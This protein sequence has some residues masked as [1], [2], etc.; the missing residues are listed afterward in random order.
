MDDKDN[1]QATLSP[2]EQLSDMIWGFTKAQLIYVAAKLEIADLLT[3]GPKDAQALALSTKINAQVLYRLMRGLAWCGLVVHLADDRF[4]LTPLGQCLQT[5]APASF[6]ENAL[7][8][9]EIDWPAWGALLKGIEIGKPGFE[10]AFGM[11]IFEYFAQ[12]EEAGSRF[13]R[14][15]GKVSAAV[16]AGIISVYDFSSFKTFIDIGGGNGTLAAAIL[17]A[18]PH[19]RGIIFDL[20][21]VIERTPLHLMPIEIADRCKAIGGD[22]FTSVPAGGDVYLMKWIIHDWPDDRCV[23]ILENCHKVMAKD[24]RLLIVEMVMP[25]QAT[26]STP[27]VMWDLH[28]MVMLNGI[29]RTEAEFRTLFSSAGF[30]L[31]HV[32]PTESGMSLI[33]GIPL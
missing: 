9:G 4:S 21:E 28:M 18:N 5:E 27:T 17:Q 12:H 22:F 31:T 3:A 2:Q 10:Y 26:P 33:E 29:E 8:M 14:L 1:L 32:I 25:E 6:H 15:M 19:L 23:K 20:P 11:E 30:N 16:S 7:S 24:A 13:D